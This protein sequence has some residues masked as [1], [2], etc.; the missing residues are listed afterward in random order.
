MHGNKP[1]TRSWP[2]V[3]RMI[4]CQ[5]TTG[6]VRDVSTP[7]ACKHAVRSLD[8]ALELLGLGTGEA[9][10]CRGLMVHRAYGRGVLTPMTRHGAPSISSVIPFLKSLDDTVPA[11]TCNCRR[12]ALRCCAGCAAREARQTLPAE[13]Q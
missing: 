5:V 2:R 8:S 12:R 4:A 10:V 9:N 7:K 6:W 3:G 11:H 13:S 1:I